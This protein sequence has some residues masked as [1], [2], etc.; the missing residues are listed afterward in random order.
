MSELSASSRPIRVALVDDQQ[1]VRVGFRMLIDSQADLEVFAEA[2][3]GVQAVE[4]ISGTAVDVVLMDVR[5]RGLLSLYHVVGRQRCHP[6]PETTDRAE[7]QP[8]RHDHFN[9]RIVLDDLAESTQ[10]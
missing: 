3:D 2:G 1:M 8:R 10:A 7:P 6:Y 9:R 5:M 4:V